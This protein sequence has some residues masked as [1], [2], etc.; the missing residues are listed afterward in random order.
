MMNEDFKYELDK[1]EMMMLNAKTFEEIE[2]AEKYSSDYIYDVEKLIE[3]IDYENMFENYI[4]CNEVVDIRIY[5]ERITLYDIVDI[6]KEY[7]R[8][9]WDIMVENYI[10]DNMT[11]DHK[12]YI[13]VIDKVYDLRAKLCEKKIELQNKN[14]VMYKRIQYSINP[15]IDELFDVSPTY[16]YFYAVCK[17]F[18]YSDNDIKKFMECSEGKE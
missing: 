14:N 13:E 9:E 8:E 7:Y 15:S 2:S 3:D 11:D 4:E 10:E 12:E 16:Y 17:A 6:L 18:G 1:L 5:N